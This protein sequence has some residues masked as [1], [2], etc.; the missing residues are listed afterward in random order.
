MNYQQLKQSL[1]QGNIAPVY[2]LYGEENYL[3]EDVLR[4]I[5]Q[6]VLKSGFRDFNYQ[7]FYGE[8]AP[9]AD[10][11]NAALTAPMVADK[12]LVVVKNVGQIKAAQLNK[13]SDYAAKPS[14]T[15]VLVLIGDKLDSKKAWVKKISSNAVAVR[16]YRLYERQAISWIMSQTGKEGYRMSPGAAQT[17]LELS[18]NDLATLANQLEKLYAYAASEKKISLEDVEQVVGRVKQHN[19][20]ELV[21]AMGNKKLEQALHILAKI[22]TQ[23]EPP[24]LVLALIGRQLRHIWRA[25]CMLAQG[26]SWERI[27]P[28]LGIPKFFLKNFVSQAKRFSSSDLQSAFHNL[29][30]IDIRLKSGT[31]CPRLSLEILLLDLCR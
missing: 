16:F 31:L 30:I 18:G 14:S 8:D 19:I 28:K 20:F 25:K 12:R 13:L 29:L 27:G 4:S 1:G 5:E 3:I 17:L 26:D 7:L 2:L 15:S 10:I 6:Q 9:T 22:M 21:E 24:Q 23:G 11:I